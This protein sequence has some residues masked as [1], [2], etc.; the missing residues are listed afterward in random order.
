MH[1]PFLRAV[2]PFLEIQ[3]S[4]FICIWSISIGSFYSIIGKFS[5][6][7]YLPS[8]CVLESNPKYLIII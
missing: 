8:H 1:H 5:Y 2:V 6:L 7:K 4:I 3:D